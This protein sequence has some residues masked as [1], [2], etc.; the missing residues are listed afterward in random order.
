MVF[1]QTEEAQQRKI[2][3]SRPPGRQ[4]DRDKVLAEIEQRH[5]AASCR[6]AKRIAD[7]MG[8]NAS[9]V[10]FGSGSKDGSMGTA[11]TVDGRDI[12]P[13]VLWTYG[14]LEIAFQWM[15]KPPFGVE[16]N[17]RELLKRLNRIEG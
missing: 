15:Q 8:Q 12:F 17:R 2:G 7:W 10:W 11:F 5:G 4:W 3:G 14:K 1:G 13:F 9:R 16:A 6:V